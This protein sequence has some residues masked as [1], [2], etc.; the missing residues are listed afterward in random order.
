M[1]KR[2][3]TVLLVVMMILVMPI[4]AFGNPGGGSGEVTQNTSVAIQE[5]QIP[6]FSR[7][8]PIL[9]VFEGIEDVWIDAIV[10]GTLMRGGPGA[11]IYL[12][13]RLGTFHRIG[14]SAYTVSDHGTR[15]YYALD[16]REWFFTHMVPVSDRPINISVKFACWETVVCEDGY[17]MPI[18]IEYQSFQFNIDS[19]ADSPKLTV[20]GC[21][22]Y[23]YAHLEFPPTSTP[24]PTPEPQIPTFSRDWSILVI[25]EGVEDVWVD[26]IVSGTFM[27]GNPLYMRS[28]IGT[29]HR[30][31]EIAYTAGD[32][33]TRFYYALDGREWY[34][35]NM[36][37]TGDRP[38]NITVKFVCWETVV[39]QDGYEVPIW[40]EYQSFQYNIDNWTG[41]PTLTVMEDFAHLGD[42]PWWPWW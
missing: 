1:K 23:G 22:C 20:T 7:D 30:I 29:F 41:S 4:T 26:A 24:Q 39:C 18:W 38:I 14:E 37:P 16:G 40:V 3:V 19:S 15:Y 17:E 21:C 36:I 25:F 35:T 9:V 6:T 28:R 2:L 31:G 12:R 8:W 5:S 34:F 32:H 13:S 10:S 42:E 11:A 33:G 27:P